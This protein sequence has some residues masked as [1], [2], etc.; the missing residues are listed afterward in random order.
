M[1]SSD[2]FQFR[3]VE[4]KNSLLSL[5]LIEAYQEK[6]ID[7]LHCDESIPMLKICAM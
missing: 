6:S 3:V 1:L 5:I 4:F 2:V 7:F